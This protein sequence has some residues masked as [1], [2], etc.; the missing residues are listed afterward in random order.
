M[1][2]PRMYDDTDPLL[3]RLR[4]LCSA[5]P[6]A[7]EFESHGRPNFRAG[8]GRVFAVYG[9]GPDHPH[10]LNVRIDPDDEDGL[11]VDPRFFVP[12]YYPDRLAL[13]LDATGT[14]WE[15]VAE[16]LESAYRTVAGPRLL[17]ALDSPR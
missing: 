5:L 3:R 4:E 2:H 14:D 9:A 16:L 15:E 11:R 8:T 7:V 17:R 10:A 13:D 12:K 6:E 1:A